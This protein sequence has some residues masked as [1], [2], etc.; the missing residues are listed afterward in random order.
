MNESEESGVPVGSPQAWVLRSRDLLERSADELDGATCSRLTRARHAALDQLE[1]R[2]HAAG[3]LR[4][5]GVAAIGLGLALV[6][7]RALLPEPVAIEAS[8]RALPVATPSRPAPPPDLPVAAPD[9]ELLAD[10]QQLALLEDL[11]FYAWLQASEED[12]GG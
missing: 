3:G 2:A 8:A 6:S 9:F 7:W 10:P 1:S 5:I 11:E 4:W 12:A